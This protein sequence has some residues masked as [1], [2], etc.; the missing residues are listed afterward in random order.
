MI[1]ACPGEV[2]NP[3]NVTVSC[4]RGASFNGPREIFPLFAIPPTSMKQ[5][6]VMLSVEMTVPG[7]PSTVTDEPF[8]TACNA[9]VTPTRPAASCTNTP[10]VEVPPATTE[11][12]GEGTCVSCS[13]KGGAMSTENG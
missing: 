12:G 11:A 5:L 9:A 4:C 13:S 7:E 2:E 6:S 3:S 1:R 10:A 8:G